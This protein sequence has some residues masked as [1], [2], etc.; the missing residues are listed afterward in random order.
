MHTRPLDCYYHDSSIQNQPVSILDLLLEY[1]RSITAALD[2]L[3]TNKPGN[4]AAN[5]RSVVTL[6]YW[7]RWTLATLSRIL[8]SGHVIDTKS[9]NRFVAARNRGAMVTH[10][11]SAGRFQQAY[12]IHVT[13]GQY[14]GG[15][16][17]DGRYDYLTKVWLHWSWRH[18]H[19][20]VDLIVA[21]VIYWYKLCQ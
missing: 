21:I 14:H 9:G 15:C 10:Q 12:L 19:S 5:N 20:R 8:Q 17:V 2:T 6:S 7:I 13:I 11:T 1:F 18:N 4:L 3:P 16:D